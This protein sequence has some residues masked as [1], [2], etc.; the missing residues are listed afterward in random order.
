MR[1]VVCL[2]LILFSSVS[3]FAQRSVEKLPKEHAAAVADYLSAN[4]TVKFRP[5]HGFSADFLEFITEGLGKGFKMSYAA[6]DFNGDKVG[7]FAMLLLRDG[8]PEP[9]GATSEEHSTDYPLRLVVFNG[10][11]GGKFRVAFTYDLMGPHAAYIQFADRRLN[12]RVF[13]TD[14]AFYLVPDGKGYKPEVEE[15]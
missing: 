10:E 14:D 3:I 7:D 15:Y 1:T 9:S 2:T 8:K 12:Y 13:E 5:Q 6:G 4:K 11:P